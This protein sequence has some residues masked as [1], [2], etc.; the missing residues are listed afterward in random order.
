VL[1]LL[2]LFATPGSA[3]A[4]DVPSDDPAVRR[5]L[6]H[7]VATETAT[8]EE[9]IELCEIP[10]PPFEEAE[11]ARA[12]VDR[13]RDA[14]LERVRIDEEGNAIGVRP[15]SDPDGPVVVFAAH[16][17]TV[18]PPGTDVTV[19][20]DGPLLRGPGIGDDCRGLAVVL[21]VARAL[22]HASVRTPGTIVFV[23]TVGEEGEGNLRG[24]RHLF[25]RGS[26][27]RADAFVS[28][29]GGGLDLVKDAVGSHRYRALFRGPGG[30][31]WGD[32]GKPS[33]IHAMG[34]AIAAIAD[35]EV[36]AD[37]RIS[38]NVG[39]VEGGTS[40]NSIAH[41]ASMRIDLRSI[42]AEALERLDRR[43]REAISA[44]VEAE[45]VRDLRHPVE[46]EVVSIGIRP[47][48]SQP[49]DAPIVR[50]AVA[51][52]RALGF[53]P[54]LL[55]ASTDA[56][57]PISLGVPAITIDG[58]G[59]GEGAHSP[60]ESYDTTDSDRGTRWALLVVTSLAGR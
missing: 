43:V 2:V 46:A 23:G 45:N 26:D 56:N 3:T 8:I 39:V 37:P 47:A 34:R 20:R 40:V 50:T 11:R 4:Q 55:A 13:L 21:A 54:R 10:A 15:G 29:D 35:L 60:D 33:P 1:P 30:H 58:G 12:F 17:D 24:V 38:F 52:A 42:H 32:F 9:Q 51:A 25:R 59:R 28:V 16:L 27:L 41:E 22:R 6:A 36:P 31:S 14:G 7:L 53:E 57:L 48:G 5:A 18:F 44:A 49:A 19:V